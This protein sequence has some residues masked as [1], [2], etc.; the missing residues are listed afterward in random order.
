MPVEYE[1]T[2]QVRHYECDAYGHLN[3]AVYLSYMQESAY[4]A[5]A[6]VGY[7]MVSYNQMDSLWYIRETKVEYLL[8]VFY[9]DTLVVRTWVADF[10]R[11]RSKRMYEIR[12]QDSQELVC[13]G[14]SDWV[15]LDRRNGLPLTIPKAMREAFM[16]DHAEQ[17]PAIRPHFPAPPPA[18]PGVLKVRRQ[19]EWRDLDP[20]RHVNNAVYAQYLQECGMQL[21]QI[22]GWPAERMWQEGYGIVARS[23]H[24]EYLKPAFL[25]DQ[26]EILTWLSQF[27]RTNVVRHY[28]I[29]REQ[30]GELL[31]QVNSRYVWVDL[32]N[33]RPI[34]I[35][36]QIKR[37]F[38]SNV[39][40]EVK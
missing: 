26:L 35:P 36:E 38:A 25:G 39:S 13:Q 16:P 19:V 31:T 17:G 21:G 10:R 34:R 3:N 29:R 20:V 5:S 9:G 30:D 22:Y 18:P 1:T 15:Y 40:E 23:H 2:F 12:K 33:G 7:D 4:Q 11:V 28:M 14:Y 8:P 6:A 24:I 37:D 32:E 27:N